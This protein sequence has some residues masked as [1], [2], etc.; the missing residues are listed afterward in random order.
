[1][2]TPESKVGVKVPNNPRIFADAKL[3][4]YL[5]TQ[6][7]YLCVVVII[8]N[9][10]VMIKIKKTASVMRHTTDSEKMATYTRVN[11]L[12]AIRKLSACS[13]LPLPNPSTTFKDNTTVYAIIDLERMTT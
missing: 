12:I 10:Y 3:G 7:S 9:V 6:K 1:M 2:T 11:I 5:S 8:F 13:G 4:C